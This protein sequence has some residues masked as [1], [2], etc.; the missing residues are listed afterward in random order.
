M[1]VNL[2]NLNFTKVSTSFTNLYPCYSVE[3]CI[4]ILS[5]LTFD[6]DQ[7]RRMSISHGE[8]RA[9][10]LGSHSKSIN[11][12]KIFPTQNISSLRESL[13]NNKF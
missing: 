1:I 12:I 5:S 4:L 8:C 2:D 3:K 11:T 6:A 7:S 10:R 13:V 9:F